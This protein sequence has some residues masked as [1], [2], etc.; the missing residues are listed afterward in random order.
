MVW[1]KLARGG[2]QLVAT[3]AV[4]LIEF[5]IKE[6]IRGKAKELQTEEADSL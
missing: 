1:S 5:T 6:K 4:L 2:L 3:S